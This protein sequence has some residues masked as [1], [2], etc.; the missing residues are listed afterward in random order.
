MCMTWGHITTICRVCFEYNVLKADDAQ[1]TVY[2]RIGNDLN[3]CKPNYFAK[4]A[5]TIQRLISMYI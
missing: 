1:M 4:E 2:T 5:M 3:L